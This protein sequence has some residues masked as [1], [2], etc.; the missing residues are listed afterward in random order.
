MKDVTQWWLET[1]NGDN[2]RS[3]LI[4]GK[5][6]SFARRNEFDL[7]GFKTLGLNHVVCYTPVEVASAIDLDVIAEC[8]EAIYHNAQ[9]LLMPR[10]PHVNFQASEQPLEAFL[11]DFPILDRLNREGRLVWYNFASGKPLPSSPRIPM[12][13]FSAEVMVNLL[14]TLGV[15]SI[16]TLGVDGG[17]SYS[18]QFDNKTRLANQHGSFDVQWPG[19]TATV[20]RYGITYAP[21]TT[22]IPI[23][24]FLGT[25]ASQMLGAKVLQYS[26]MKHCP[27]P[28]VF[29]TM[30]DILAPTPKHP[31]NQ[32]HTEFSFNR[33]AIPKRAGYQGRA[34][35][36][37]ADMLVCRNFQELW[38]IPFNQA[39]VLYAASSSPNRMR[40]F[41][42]LLL[43]C[44]ELA[45][46][47]NE[48]IMGLDN[49]SYDYQDLMND[50]CIERSERVQ[51]L[52]PSEWNSLEEYQP[53]K[54]A[55]IH[56][57]D[58]HM[59]PWVSCKNPNGDLWVKYLREAIRAD[60]ISFDEV[61]D[62]VKQGFAR[63]SLLKQLKL[64]KRYWP[65]FTA[66]VGPIIDRNYKPHRKLRRRL[67]SL[68]KA[69]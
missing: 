47:I 38:D 44:D 55:L 31:K 2:D 49:E 24:V 51:P 30:E 6:P 64:S 8:G 35:Y 52:I 27:I 17:K 48:I 36:L 37:D 34:V 1:G 57:T 46:D 67:K 62:A 33:F 26:I 58:M 28:V 12:G 43:K 23:R 53:G 7:T 21:L 5:G 41:S 59:Q 22:E 42:V 16:C 10:Y 11:G 9:V 13:Y 60:F 40:Q 65:F 4:L 45:W 15:R 3:W 20:R 39:S 61:K 14:A 63:P 25:D 56:Y 29:D 66:Y 54:T 68:K 19:I 69:S 18:Q 50:F 32:A